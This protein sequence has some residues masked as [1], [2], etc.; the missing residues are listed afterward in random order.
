MKNWVMLAAAV[1]ALVVFTIPTSTGCEME[2]RWQARQNTLFYNLDATLAFFA[3]SSY[4]AN[5]RLPDTVYLAS[6]F[7]WL[8]AINPPRVCAK[9]TIGYKLYQC[10]CDVTE[11]G[12]FAADPLPPLPPS[13]VRLGASSCHGNFFILLNPLWRG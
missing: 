9:V 10:K 2:G 1:L 5:V 3:N 7:S 4:T 12:S 6:L 13:S 8:M 11:E